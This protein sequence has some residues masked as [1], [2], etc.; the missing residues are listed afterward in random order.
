MTR[1]WWRRLAVAGALLA[2]GLLLSESSRRQPQ[3]PPAARGAAAVSEESEPALPLESPMA[4][5][6]ISPKAAAAPVQTHELRMGSRPAILH[7]EDGFIRSGNEFATQEFRPEGVRVAGGRGHLDL[8]LRDIRMGGRSL[9]GGGWLTDGKPAV[10]RGAGEHVVYRRG[11]VTEKYALINEGVEQFF[12]L[13]SELAAFRR[14][15]DLTVTVGLESPLKPARKVNARGVREDALEFKDAAGASALTYGGAVAIDADGKRRNLSY[16]LRGNELAMVLDA[17]FLASARFPLTIDPAI[18]VTP[19]SLTFIAPLGGPNPAPQRLA[20]SNSGAGKL[21]WTATPSDPWII[22]SPPQGARQTA[23]KKNINVS[24]DVSTL[25]EGVHTGHSITFDGNTGGNPP[26]VV[27][28]IVIINDRPTIALNPTS[29]T[30]NS[31]GGVGT[32][33]PLPQTVT[34][35][36]V[37]PG[38]LTW[39]AAAS[40]TPPGGTWLSVTPTTGDL[41]P[42]AT[43]PLTIS[44]DHTGLADG[45]YTGTITV[46]NNSTGF[47]LPVIQA[48]QTVTV[49][50]IVSSAPVLVLS[51]AA[52][53]TFDI[54]STGGTGTA[55]LPMTVSNGG[56]GTLNWTSAASVNTPAGGT[57]LGVSPPSGSLGPGAS[58]TLTVTVTRGALAAG[59][60]DGQITVTSA[61]AA[62][63]PEWIDIFLNVNDQ[64]TISLVPSSLTFTAA[65]GGGVPPSQS[66]SIG[67]TGSGTLSWTA[68]KVGTVPWLS[69]SPGN[70]SVASGS[71]TP[72]TVS[73]NQAGLSPGTVTA[74]IEISDANATNPS[75]I[76]FVTLDVVTTPTIGLNPTIFN[77]SAPQNGTPPLSQP[78]TVTNAG[79]GTLDW[80]ATPSAPWILVSPDNGSLGSGAFSTP[81][82]SVN[83]GIL[84]PGTYNGTIQIAATG[85]SN[86]P[87][88][89]FVTMVINAVPTIGFSPAIGLTFNAP[90]GG[91][92]PPS[93]QLTITNTGSGTLNWTATSSDP[94]ITTISPAGGALT[95][96]ASTTPPITV[97]VT[98]G[99]LAAGTY[100]GS[101][102]ITAAG[103]SNTPQTVPVT[104]NVNATPTIGLSLTTFNFT[105]PQNGTPPATQQVTVSNQGTGTLNWVGTPSD[106]WLSISS[107][108]GGLAGGASELATISVNQGS[109]AAGVYNGS[110]SISASGASNDP[111][112]INVTLTVNATPTIGLSS[113]S[114]TFN[115][116]EGGAPPATQQVT[117][118]NAGT[119]TLNWVG[120]PSD[121]WLSI[122]AS[123]GGLSGGASEPAT[124]TVNQGVLAAGTYNG[125]ITIAASGASNTPQ[126][127]NVTLNVLN[128]PAI[129]LSPGNLVFS[130]FVGGSA[131]A[132]QTVTLTNTGT[133][134]L[135]WTA[136]P[137]AAWISIVPPASGSLGSSALT[138]LTIAVDPTGL[139]AGGQSSAITV[140]AAGASN[141]PQLINVTLNLLVPTS[142]SIPKAGYCGA[143]GLELLLPFALLWGYRRF[144]RNGRTLGR[145]GAFLAVLILGSAQAWAGGD[146]LPR[147]LQ[148]EEPPPRPQAPIPPQPQAEEGE[149]PDVLDFSKSALDAHVGFLSFSSKFESSAKFVG[150]VQYRVPS[151]LLSSIVDTDPE[152]IGIFLDISVSSIDRDIPATFD[153]SGTL[154]FVTLGTDAAFY[155]DEDWDFRGQVG[156][157]Y[158][159]FGGVDGL[160]DGIAFL[161]GLRGGLNV[162]DGIWIVLNPQF[163]IAKE[164]NNIFFVNVGAEIKF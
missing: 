159:N 13:D 10:E 62:N 115:A 22:C 28:I 43:A 59:S 84:A 130:A 92:A 155:K 104:L 58:T 42:I 15:G 18:S 44:V 5:L 61:D 152:R 37:G 91:S 126:T 97:G 156:V 68:A 49:T 119:G 45:T 131:P 2:L 41:A 106:T 25:T 136:T 79:S 141:D 57:W 80:T 51:P 34:V 67:N 77:F 87:Q 39:G 1:S 139:P 88:T 8:A 122:S 107:S 157:Q 127:I 21:K 60:Y 6:G 47:S 12:V 90:E 93:Q 83:Q 20:L 123:A 134:T 26:V 38:T 102:T 158:G 96:G 71:T 75:E 27:D 63:S 31:P 78:L 72:L 161:L 66:V 135:N 40:T 164:S 154:F 99:V 128:T 50:L 133:G 105:A 89:I 24:I 52:G 76:I 81:A 74:E 82:V 11:S 129:G 9:R 163:A 132:S 54:G 95:A 145:L 48:P 35:Q 124:I 110:I 138:T 7:A 23:M 149:N 103:A 3:A 86:T 94:W 114:F 144:R 55:S 98:Q 121:T 85:A 32:P 148:Q 73:V 33:N 137:G 120:T 142:I 14:E 116:P 30:F 65:Q 53:L 16:E 101:I 162:G 69:F 113:T 117:V 118:S 160:D 100:N 17:G 111:Q 19:T 146:E 56:G 29:L 143:T 108:A 151:P 36:N 147:S 70:G 150:G 140:S 64:P 4:A 46:T 153:R 112:T 109:L 125:T